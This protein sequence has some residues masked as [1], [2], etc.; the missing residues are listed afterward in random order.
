MRIVYKVL[1]IN[2]QTELGKEVLFFFFIF[3][4]IW[5][6]FLSYMVLDE[7]LGGILLCDRVMW[8]RG[9]GLCPRIPPKTSSKT[10]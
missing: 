2:T 8:L 6:F 5:A 10:I 4:R 1:F 7:V 9:I 3:T